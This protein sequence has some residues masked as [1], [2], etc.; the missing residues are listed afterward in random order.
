MTTA[1][2]TSVLAY[3][4][5]AV[6]AVANAEQDLASGVGTLAQL[7]TANDALTQANADV[8][9]IAGKWFLNH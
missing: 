6:A 8:A 2:V 5:A 9:A 4:V 3:Q 1:I 7:K